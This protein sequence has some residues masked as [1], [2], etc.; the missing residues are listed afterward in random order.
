MYW[1]RDSSPRFCLRQVRPHCGTPT[2]LNVLRDLPLC[3]RES[4]LPE[5]LYVLRIRFGRSSTTRRAGLEVLGIPKPFCPESRA[6]SKIR[7][8]LRA[9]CWVDLNSQRFDAVA[10]ASELPDHSRSAYSLQPFAHNLTAFLV[11]DASVQDYPDQPTEAI[12][13]CPDGLVVSQA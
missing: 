5:L 8:P 2:R 6:G 3:Y 7:G 10:E 1:E 13:N 12:S 11:T 9:S 4:C